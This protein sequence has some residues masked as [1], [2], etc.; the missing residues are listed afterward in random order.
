MRINSSSLRAWVG[1]LVLAGLIGA[2]AG[3]V[4]AQDV[5]AQFTEP[6]RELQFAYANGFEDAVK[7]L[8]KGLKQGKLDW[9]DLDNLARNKRGL[10]QILTVRMAKEYQKTLIKLNQDKTS[11]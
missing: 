10:L 7:Y 4:R 9:D 1:V 6:F 5:R 3:P 2:G 8:Y 11:Q